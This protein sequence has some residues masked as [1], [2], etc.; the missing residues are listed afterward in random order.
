M[1][2]FSLLCTLPS[3][4]FELLCI[5]IDLM[6]SAHFNDTSSLFTSLDPILKSERRSSSRSFRRFQEIRCGI[7]EGINGVLFLYLEQKDEHKVGKEK[8]IQK[9]LHR[10]D[11]CYRA[12]ELTDRILLSIIINRNS[13]P[14][15]GKSLALESE[16]A[17]LAHR[18]SA[19][20][21]RIK[22]SRSEVQEFASKLG[23]RKVFRTADKTAAKGAI[24]PT[25]EF[26]RPSF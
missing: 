21:Q 26:P 23:R 8:K 15:K 4:A 1:N 5:E 7:I 16:V 18:H 9:S 3:L 11:I 20:Y 19:P 6:I 13:S 22:S 2:L 14:F 25:C 17:K 12:S 10:Q 24:A